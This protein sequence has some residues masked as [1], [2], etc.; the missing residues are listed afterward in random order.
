[1]SAE[2]RAPNLTEN[3]AMLG[4]LSH[5]TRLQ[6]FRLL[7]TKGEDGMPATAIADAVGIRQNLM[8][9]HLS[10][11]VKS[12]LASSRRDGRRVFYSLDYD[13]VS[14]LLNFLVEDC[15]AGAP[16]GCGLAQDPRP[17]IKAAE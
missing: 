15:C 12:G 14:A 4:A 5:E 8:S 13:K 3:A 17:K 6:V 2:T 11:L 16:A 7:M 1:M 10:M 9:A